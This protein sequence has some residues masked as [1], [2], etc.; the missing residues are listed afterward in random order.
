MAKAKKRCAKPHSVTGLGKCTAPTIAKKIGVP[1]VTKQG[2]KRTKK[3]LLNMAKAMA[4]AKLKRKLHRK[5]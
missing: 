2:K 1:Y 5:A 3:T 4:K